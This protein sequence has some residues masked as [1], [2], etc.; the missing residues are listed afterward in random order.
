MV[1][2]QLTKDSDMSHILKKLSIAGAGGNRNQPKPPVYKPPI[3]GQLQYGAS[4]SFAETIDLIS[5]GPIEGLVDQDGQLLQGI[6]IL[7]GI[8]LDDTPVAVSN[9]PQLNQEFPD[10]EL[11]A[12]EILNCVLSNGTNTA[13]TN[14]KRFFRELSSADERSRDARISTL[15]SDDGQAPDLE[16]Q[17][18]P[19]CSLYYRKESKEVNTIGLDEGN[20]F[21][22]KV[23]TEGFG[24]RAF[25]KDRVDDKEFFAFYNND[26]LTTL[27]DDNA[28]FSYTERLPSD[29]K[30][31]HWM[32]FANLAN[33]NL[34]ISLY[35]NLN[36]NFYSRG[37]ETRDGENPFGEDHH[38]S[39]WG[40]VLGSYSYFSESIERT[41]EF[42]NDDLNSLRL[43]R[44]ESLRQPGFAFIAAQPAKIQLQLATKAL[45][46]LGDW[47]NLG[48][49]ELLTTAVSDLEQQNQEN[50]CLLVVAKVSETGN[51]SLANTD[52]KAGSDDE[53]L[54]ILEN[55]VTR[56]FGTEF[57]YTLQTLLER[58]GVKFFDVTSPTIDENGI[59]TGDITGFVLIKIPLEVSNVSIN[60]LDHLQTLNQ[61]A[62]V[63]EAIDSFGLQR[64]NSDFYQRGYTYSVNEEVYRL[65]SDIESFKYT[66]TTLP[67]GISS[68]YYYD[69]L[70]FNFSNVLAE[71][72]Q[73]SEYQNPLSYFKT[74]FID[75]IYNREL[76]GAFNADKSASGALSSP[77][78]SKTQRFA[79]QRISMNPDMLTKS[80]VLS[81]DTADNFNLTVGDDGLPV[82]EGSD[83]ERRTGSDEI[84]KNYSE[85]AKRSL[86]SWN[87]DAVSVIHTVYNP[88]VNRAFIS[89]NVSNLSDTLTFEVTPTDSDNQKMDIASKF[90]AVLNIRVETGS[91]GITEEGSQGLEQPYKTYNY[92]IVA[93]IEGGTIID[94]GNPDY[95]GDSSRE[96]VVNLDGSDTNLNAGFELPPAITNKESIL[97]ADGESGIE[98]GTIDADSTV[99]R[100][101][102]ITK[103]SFET[104][105]VLINKIVSVD[106]VT[107]I[108]DT[109]L[110]Y[111]FSSIVGTKLDSKSFSAI[112]RRTFDCKLKKVKIPS[113]YDPV[114]P[115][116]KDKRY[117]NNSEEFNSTDKKDKL[118][119]NGDWDG[120][121]KDGLHWTDNPAWILYDLLT[122]NRYGMGTHIDPSNINIWELYNIGR[123]CDAV[124]DLGFFKGVSDGRGGKEPRFSCNIVFDQGQKIFDAINT[125]AAIFRGRVFFNDTTISF[126]DDRPRNPV[127]IFTNETV[128][129]GLFFYSNNRRDEQFNT[130]EVAFNDRFDNFVPKIEVVEDED[131]IKEKG[132]FKK[133]IEGVG[134]TS[135]AMAR[136]VAQH[137]IF[138]KIKENQSVAFTAGLE[139]LLCKPGDLVLIEDDLKTNITNY[140]KVLAVDATNQTI[141]VSNTANTTDVN[142]ILTVYNP[143][144][145][146]S[147]LE[148]QT[149]FAD[150]NRVRYA[151][152]EVT[153]EDHT[154]AWSRFTGT[155]SFSGYTQGYED[156]TG[157]QGDPRYQNYASYTG[158]PSSG[159]ILYFHTGV[160]GWV[161]GSGVA[162]TAEG[163]KSAFTLLSGNL[164][165]ELTGDHTLAAVGTGK[166]VEFDFSEADRRTTNAAKKYPFSGF[167]PQAYIGRSERGAL[168]SD[169]NNIR[170]DQLA[171][172]DVTTIFS[173][174]SQLEAEG[175]NDYGSLLSG[176]DK[177]EIL[178]SIKVG[179]A[180]RLQIKNANPF[181]YKVISMQEEN[182]N[183][184]LVTATKYDTGKYRLIEDNISIENPANTFSYQTA[185][186]IN[187]VTYKTLDAPTLSIV[188]SGVPNEA[189]STFSISGQWVAVS[190]S[191]GYNV[192]L[193]LPNG[194]LATTN[195]TDTLFQFNGLSQ[196][197]SFRYSVNAL[198]NKGR[199][200][201]SDAYFDSEYDSSGI[202][203][204]YDDALIFNRSFI[205]KITIL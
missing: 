161:F 1:K 162:H 113:N 165:S 205:E 51:S 2:E 96:Y 53:G 93:L 22:R 157:A 77:E 57:G 106:K 156:A 151:E 24:L 39:N 16:S 28:R 19:D 3:L 97:S 203:V 67:L 38:W 37:T 135:R 92:R 158:T 125:I 64:A 121:L 143:T 181:I 70:K 102:K 99:K 74:V 54:P 62:D 176:F 33:S 48:N 98:A 117:Y 7:Q 160:T 190:N 69:D 116:G 148:I 90:P 174:P 11:E 89:L 41:L 141:R 94:I 139:S 52:I 108:I 112:P 130:I 104:N 166:F 173:T 145:A 26:R 199:D 188:T 75:H 180:A 144:G 95:R 193:D 5:D 191:T 6:R 12:A 20:A 34:M 142:A 32:D 118:V 73:G 138:S 150:L 122:N 187:G 105:S 192:K 164:I 202:F 179:S 185:Q 4:H 10:V 183:E 88:N 186:T 61:S 83:D 47:A 100:Y 123:F 201:T 17:A 170:P 163:D 76:F 124:D 119:Y 140:G 152:L 204:V 84:P 107:E 42:I 63:R 129:D 66:K 80:E 25:I 72:R 115:N 36:L 60:L 198:G 86:V 169:L 114:L 15:N 50:P 127:N 91:L 136:R 56:P 131:N 137:Q 197:G 23:N 14:L 111:P 110:P 128:K 149:G 35:T 147:Q 168:E 101:V 27:D 154:V 21:I 18:W 195:T 182:I 87:E 159:T 68:E 8:Y 31:V 153:G 13:V 189:D 81:R 109:P 146:D 120:S 177:P 126:V 45:S 134:I 171:T 30:S 103:L 78:V 175:L 44:E 184:Y 9:K 82:A 59:L 46:N 55:M 167:N 40:S 178:N 71:F 58:R 133:R 196:V 200:N 85:W 65:I 155:Y 172:L 132:I 194:G 29:H 49:E 79:P 43:Q